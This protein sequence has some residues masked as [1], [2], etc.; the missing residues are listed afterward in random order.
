MGHL[1]KECAP[2]GSQPPAFAPLPLVLVDYIYLILKAPVGADTYR[3][4]GLLLP[5]FV[6]S[7]PLFLPRYP[8][9]ISLPTLDL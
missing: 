1:E 2:I 6:M 9:P 4:P 7:A 3:R 8:V 5:A